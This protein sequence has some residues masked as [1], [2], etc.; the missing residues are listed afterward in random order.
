MS[1]WLS[2][3]LR[4][5]IWFLVVMGCFLAVLSFKLGTLVPGF[6]ANE[7]NARAASSTINELVRNPLGMPFKAIQF[8]LQYAGQTGPTAMR[9][10]GVI[11]G[12]VT[13]GSLYLILNAWYTRRVAMLGTLLFASSS[14]FLHSA[15]LGTDVI[16]YSL[17]IV[18]V[19]CVVWLRRSSASAG[20]VIIGAISLAA[21]FYV[22]GMIWFI[23][24]LCLWQSRRIAGLLR[25]QYATFLTL[26]TLGGI[27]LLAPIGWALF[28]NPALIK[29][30]F[31]LPQVLPQPMD[32]IRGIRDVPI[33]LFWRSPAN[34]ETNLGTLPLVDW[35]GTVMFFLGLYAYFYKRRLDRTWFL[36]YVFIAGTVLVALGGPVNISVLLP[37]VYLM[38]VGG[39]A[40]MMQQWLTVF[41]RNPVARYIG[42]SLIT[43]AVLLSSFYNLRA[44]FVAWPSAPETKAVF[45]NK[46]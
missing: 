30:F 27:A 14:W 25:D 1:H 20:P 16:L 11:L 34:P 6:S 43:V 3:R 32:V 17:L 9:V 41:P 13:A 18:V 40:L 5:V 38:I 21:L 22:P 42:L 8:S 29:T 31:G 37:F 2:R 23:I 36:A 15:R 28:Q 35:F 26:V 12:L 45:H 44:Y 46:P 7:L 33:H 39:V 19:A 4:P 10:A 24:P